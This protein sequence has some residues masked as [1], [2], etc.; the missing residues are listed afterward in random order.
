MLSLKMEQ[1]ICARC[2]PG[3]VWALGIGVAGAACSWCVSCPS[4]DQ[5]STNEEYLD[6]IP[7]SVILFFFS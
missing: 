4:Q 6:G 5:H 2:P 1:L 3:G 7:L